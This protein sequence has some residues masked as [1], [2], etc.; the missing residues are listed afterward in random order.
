MSGI[1]TISSKGQIVLPQPIRQ[2]LGIQPSDS[3]LVSLQ[4]SKI[5]V[6]K[7]AKSNDFLGAFPVEKKVTRKDIKSA[8]RK[9]VLQKHAKGMR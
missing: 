4:N 9:H 3:F 5:I 6:E 2:A 1:T 7:L 8:V